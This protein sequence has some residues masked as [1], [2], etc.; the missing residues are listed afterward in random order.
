M[1]KSVLDDAD[2]RLL[3]MRCYIFGQLK[4]LPVCST[5]AIAYLARFADV[6]LDDCDNP[7]CDH[8]KLPP[9][10]GEQ[11][12]VGTPI[13]VVIGQI[14]QLVAEKQTAKHNEALERDS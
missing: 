14:E 1:M 10:F 12:P 3:L 11:T 13:G 9:H 6:R 8:V 4:G 2:I 5:A 7:E